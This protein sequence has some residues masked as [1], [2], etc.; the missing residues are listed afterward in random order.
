MGL[1]QWAALVLAV[2]LSVVGLT[3]MATGV[4]K[5]GRDLRTQW[6]QVRR[7]QTT[8]S[9]PALA[10]RAQLILDDLCSRAAVPYVEVAV[11]PILG[12]LTATSSDG[13]G[14]GGLA[15]TRFGLR[16]PPKILLANGAAVLSYAGL[17][18]LLAHE[19]AHA[20]RYSVRS[21]VVRHFVL[22]VPFFL[23]IPLM[24]W[25]SVTVSVSVALLVT[26]LAAFAVLGWWTWL[27]RDEEISA[28]LYAI[29]LT[30]DL[31]G[32]AELMNLY[33]VPLER[34]PHRSRLI[35]SFERSFETHPVPAMRLE[36]M[37]GRLTAR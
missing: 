25:L 17:E 34:R 18:A 5:L 1:I 31:A 20:V 8:R 21:A 13:L 32:A 22:V 4:I 10:R 12:R 28:D 9:D 3:L 35:Q 33:S 19:L 30:A 26:L 37:R 29:D 24:V 14:T 23:T 11:V 36:M 27:A 2:A 7:P 16:E 15:V 6:S